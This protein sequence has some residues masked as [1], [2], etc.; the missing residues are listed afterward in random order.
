VKNLWI[1]WY[2]YRSAVLYAEELS[3]EAN[4][5]ALTVINTALREFT[6]FN[7][8]PYPTLVCVAVCFNRKLP[9]NN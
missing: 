2:F 4:T 3:G 7:V 1:T 8:F 9:D 5:V 6:L